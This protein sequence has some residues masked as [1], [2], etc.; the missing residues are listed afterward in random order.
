MVGVGRAAR[1]EV[2]TEDLQTL[3]RRVDLV[4]QV[5]HTM[6]KKLQTC[7]Q[8]Q[9]GDFER[10]L[11]RVTSFSHFLLLKKT[12]E[13]GLYHSMIE[14]ANLLGTDTLLGPMMKLCGD[15]QGNLAHSLVNYEIAVETKVTSPIQQLLENE[16]PTIQKLRKQLSRLTLDMDS[17]RTR[18]QTA[19]RQTQGGQGTSTTKVDAI[20]DELDEAC[21]KVQQCRDQ[22]AT[23]MYNF[24]A[25]ESEYSELLIEL[26]REQTEYHRQALETLDN[27]LPEM[28]EQLEQYCQIPVYGLALEEHLRRSNR[29]IASVLE[30]CVCTLLHVGMEEEGLFRI[31]GSASRLKKLKAA[32]NSGLVDM[33][34][35]IMDIPCVASALKQYLRELPEPLMTHALYDEW[36]QAAYLAPEER[37]NVFRL[38]LE[39]MPKANYN[40]L[41]YLIKFLVKLSEKSDVN[42]MSARPNL[43]W[44]PGD[45]S[46]S[47]VSSG[48]QAS[49]VETLINNADTLFPGGKPQYCRLLF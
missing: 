28:T 17:V 26:V 9:S 46:P 6:V 13:A 7:S 24:V 30:E 2:L 3:E 39:K 21:T 18:Y 25:R 40:N 38:V 41:R 34:D 44:P 22:L 33:S 19:A 4:K 1:S 15:A 27:M 16:I 36:M 48:T 10:R 42:K 8:S 29:D 43:L 12:P 31:A 32:L 49:I 11:V 14:S 5:W 45:N 23:E 35:Y 20:R 37:L 47:V